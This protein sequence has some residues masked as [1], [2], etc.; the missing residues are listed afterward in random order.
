MS[1]LLRICLLG[2]MGVSLFF[3]SGCSTAYWA[4][5][6]NDALDI[7]D[8]GVTG[9]STPQFGL[10]AGFLNVLSIGYSNFDGT[11]VGIGDR[12]VGG[13]PAR[14]HATGLVL[15]GTEQFAYG[16]FSPANG[17]EP[18]A[19]R[20]GLMGL[21]EGPR[22]PRGQVLNCP[23]ILHLGFVGLT[24]NCRF[25]ELADFLLG[26]FTLDPMGDDVH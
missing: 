11:L 15:W 1:K 23:K 26:W 18:E 8:V 10:Y 25:G 7:F 4:N 22:P 13:M 20:V 21:A 17:G 16:E 19:W 5:R 9:S 3:F 2:M 24:L 6:G 14:Q 12:N